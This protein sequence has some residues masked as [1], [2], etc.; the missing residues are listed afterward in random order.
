MQ[1][2][3]LSEGSFTIDKTKVFLPFD[4]SLEALNSRPVGSLLVEI[5]PFV[6]ITAKDVILLDTGLGYKDAQGNAQLHANLLK[7]GINPSQVTKVLMSHLHKD[8]AGGITIQGYHT[9]ERFISFPYAQY[10]VQKRE[11]DHALQVGT[12]SYIVE[13]FQLLEAFSKVVWLDEDEG[14]IDE[15][16]QFELTGGHSLYHQAFWIHEEG[17]TAFYGGDV[18]PQLQQM[19]SRFVA[20]YDYDGKKC[21]ELRQRW[22]LEGQ[23][24][25]WN[26]L[27]YHDIQS[28]VWQLG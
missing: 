12:A 11:F 16:I 8:H 7:A 5:Q 19:K 23:A 25:H 1:I 9:E 14:W 13:D 6:V 18:A 24:K 27:F 15:Y 28:P 21:M 3:P 20:K 2:I 17:E 26:F 10:Y 4:V 22:W